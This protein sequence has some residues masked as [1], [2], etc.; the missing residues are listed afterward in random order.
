MT[1][2]LLFGLAGAMGLVIGAWRAALQK[3]RL[4]PAERGP[5]DRPYVTVVVPVRDEEDGIAGVLQ[6]LHAQHYPKELFEVIVVDDASSDRTA[7]IVRGMQPR[8][9]Q[10]ALIANTGIGKKAAIATAVELAKGD[11]VLLTDGDARCG[12]KRMAVMAALW[13]EQRSDCLIAPVWTNGTGVM[14]G[15]QELEQVGLVGAALGS[16]LSGK[17]ILAYG[18]N[19]AFARS[20]FQ[21]VGGYAGDRFASGDDVFLVQR[22]LRSG[23]KVSAIADREAMVE[24]EAE[25]TWG[26]FWRQRLRWAGKVRGMGAAAMV[27][28]VLVLLLPWV[29]AWATLRF[30]F[31]GSMGGQALYAALLLA[32][33]WL[34]WLLPIIGFVRDAGRT[35]GKPVKAIHA[36]LALVAFTVYAPIIGLLA[37]VWRPKWKGRRV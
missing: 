12:P 10:L 28:G 29:L 4:L 18:A 30:D 23:G 33:A 14:G 32:G 21:R 22:L 8:W 26:G 31:V 20:A 36:L 37:L 34:C 17:P 7:D 35:L 24:V 6:D 27:G 11:L 15:L 9:P 25:R 2:L 5:V 1:A 19:L 3:A 13:Q 16:A